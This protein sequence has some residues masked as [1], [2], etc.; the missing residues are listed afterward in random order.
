MIVTD[1]INIYILLIESLFSFLTLYTFN[2]FLKIF[3]EKNQFKMGYVILTYILFFIIIEVTYC[4]QLSPIVNT[5]VSISCFFLI[6]L[7]YKTSLLNKIVYTTIYVIIF[8]VFELLILNIYSSLLNISTNA[9]LQDFKLSFF[10]S[11][12]SKLIPFLTIK[13]YNIITQHK[14]VSDEPIPLN[15]ILQ[16]LTIPVISITI[17]QIA[18]DM[19][20]Q[21][22]N[23]MSLSITFC[24]FFIN[25]LFLNI[26]EKLSFMA[27]EKVENIILNNQIEY[28]LSLYEN[29]KIEKNETLK[30]KHNIKN[31]ILKIKTLLIEQKKDEAMDELEK[32][33]EINSETIEVFSEISIID[34]IINYKMQ[35]A[36]KNNVE[37]KHRISLKKDVYVNY[38]DMTNI[39]G[40]ALDN[41]IEAC[42]KNVDKN[43]KT[44][45]LQ[46]HQKQNNIYIGISNPYEQDILFKNDFPLS[47]KR[48][49]EYGIGLKTIQKIIDKKNN[50][51]KITTD[52][53]IFKLECIIF[54]TSK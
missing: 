4:L 36:K 47:S 38:S 6:S 2:L 49:N 28:Y 22:L 12:T 10:L 43:N 17:L 51:M 40:N 3:F 37:I 23:H 1:S 24:V 45:N 30:I 27:K 53:K 20:E 7:F 5:L 46:M 11:A 26:Y 29:I 39:L 50:I 16:L 52:D 18:I 14:S 15:L 44:I 13:I 32:I 42:I 34:A 25:I 9:I 19:A 48:K 33:L 21:N 35:F 8:V 31:N 41:A 54:E